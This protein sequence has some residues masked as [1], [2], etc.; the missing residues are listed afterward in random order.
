VADG[1]IPARGEVAIVIAG[2]VAD[3]RADKES[4]FPISEA[5]AR[6]A[7]LIRE[8]ASRTDAA[9]QIAAETGHSRR[10]LYRES[11]PG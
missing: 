1:S 5:R 7:S 6:V 10:D 8:G 11:E 9:R 2:H 4:R 3:E